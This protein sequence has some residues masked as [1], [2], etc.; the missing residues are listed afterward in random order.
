MKKILNWILKIFKALL[1]RFHHDIPDEPPVDELSEEIDV[2]KLL[3]T[4]YLNPEIIKSMPYEMLYNDIFDEIGQMLDA[5]ESQWHQ[6]EIDYALG[7][8]SM[9]VYCDKRID[10]R[11]KVEASK[12]RYLQV[13]NLA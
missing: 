5:L 2:K 3:N 6:N 13:M 9:E 8:I 10:I 11:D 1:Q 12:K 4:F 7:Y